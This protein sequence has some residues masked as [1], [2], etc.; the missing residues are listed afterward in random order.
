M[1][2]ADEVKQIVHNELS[3]QRDDFLRKFWYVIIAMIVATASAWFGLYYQVQAI[4]LRISNN[5]VLIQRQIDTLR[6]DYKTDI[7]DIK[8]DIRI[9][10]DEITRSNR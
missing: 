4:D 10:R 5:D 3:T 1:L 8:T 9:I 6:L 7:A 2:T